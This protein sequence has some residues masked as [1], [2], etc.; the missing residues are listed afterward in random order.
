MS[1]FFLRY[2]K[3]RNSIDFFGYL[4]VWNKDVFEGISIV[5]DFCVNPYYYIGSAVPKY[6]LSTQASGVRAELPTGIDVC[7]KST[8]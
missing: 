5:A 3:F 2:I 6:R 8:P 1:D 4:E 7:P